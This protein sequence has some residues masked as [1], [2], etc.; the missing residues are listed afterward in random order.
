MRKADERLKQYGLNV[1]ESDNPDREPVDFTIEDGED[2]VAWVYGKRYELNWECSHPVEPT[3]DGDEGRCPVCGAEC[4]WHWEKQVVDE[5]HDEEGNYT[6]KEAEVRVVDGWEDP[7]K[8]RG[9][10][11]DYYKEAYGRK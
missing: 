4:E 2:N 5:G 7:L 8:V 6:C 10:I 3:W 9:L 11:Y 1:R